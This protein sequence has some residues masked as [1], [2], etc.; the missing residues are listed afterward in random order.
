MVL[1][2]IHADKPVFLQPCNFNYT[3]EKISHAVLR[4]DHELL[5]LRLIL[6]S[7]TVLDVI[8][9]SLQ[10]SSRRLG[11]SLSILILQQSSLV[12]A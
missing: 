5:K 8:S 9:T 6:F 7:S 3:T 12:P 2:L 10:T 11:G 4:V 1:L